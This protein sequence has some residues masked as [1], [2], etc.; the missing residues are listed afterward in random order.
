MSAMSIPR[1]KKQHFKLTNFLF[2]LVRKNFKFCKECGFMG[3]VDRMLVGH[4]VVSHDSRGRG[5]FGFLKMGQLPR[6]H[7][8]A[9]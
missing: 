4:W 5:R 3:R 1:P 6:S 2:N 7:A 9:F 8:A